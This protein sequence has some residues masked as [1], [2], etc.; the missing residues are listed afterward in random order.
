[1]RD[2]LK[3]SEFWSAMILLVL[4]VAVFP[5]ALSLLSQAKGY[6]LSAAQ[7]NLLY[8]SVSLLLVALLLGRYLRRSFD[9]LIDAPGRCVHCPRHD[10][11]LCARGFE[12]K[13]R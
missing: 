10:S 3:K 4:H 2:R 11:V 5:I 6:S 9:G 13:H 7:T 8:Y 12:D 1:M